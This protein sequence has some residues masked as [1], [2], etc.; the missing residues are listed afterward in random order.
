MLVINTWQ[1]ILITETMEMGKKRQLEAKTE[2]LPQILLKLN[3][4]DWLVLKMFSL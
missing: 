4:R 1:F 2:I 3:L